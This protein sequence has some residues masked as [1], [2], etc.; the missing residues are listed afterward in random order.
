MH[1]RVKCPVWKNVHERLVKHFQYVPP[2]G[3]SFL[4]FS[5][6][7]LPLLC[8]L[9]LSPPYWFLSSARLGIRAII[10]NGLMDRT[11]KG[12]ESRRRGVYHVACLSMKCYFKVR[13]SSFSCLSSPSP[14]LSIFEHSIL[15]RLSSMRWE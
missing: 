1:K 7:L 13:P 2:T 14:L 4:F 11:F 6:P 12:F 5:S 3:E 9:S 15:G 10:W 8:L